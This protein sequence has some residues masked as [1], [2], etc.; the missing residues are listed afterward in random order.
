[1]THRGMNDVYTKDIVL[2]HP[3]ICVV[4]GSKPAL[5]DSGLYLL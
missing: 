3:L 4:A 1:M 2:L 5:L